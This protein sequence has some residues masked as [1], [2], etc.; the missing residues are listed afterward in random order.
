MWDVA[1]GTLVLTLEG[2]GNL[3]GINVI[4]FS[5]DGA[6]MVAAGRGGVMAWDAKTGGLLHA[7]GEGTGTPTEGS[8]FAI[9]PDGRRAVSGKQ[10][11]KLWDVATGKSLH[12]FVGLAHPT[13]ALAVS[14]DGK[15]LLIGDTARTMR[16]WNVATG[17][18]VQS[19]NLRGD[20]Y[21]TPDF[22][23]AA[24]NEAQ[25]RTTA[26]TRDG[27]RLQLWDAD[28]GQKISAIEG[29]ST[30]GTPVAISADGSRVAAGGNMQSLE[31][32]DRSFLQ[33][34]VT[35]WDA[36]NGQRVRDFKG[37]VG[38]L[39]SLAFSPDGSR[40]ASGG[41]N[42][43]VML[44][45]LVTGDLVRS[46]EAKSKPG[47]DS[48][49]RQVS[50]AVTAVAFSP[51]GKLLLSAGHEG[52][53]MYLWNAS[54]GRPVRSWEA[55]P[56]IAAL[57]FSA[58]GTLVASGG[59]DSHI[60]LWEVATGRLVHTFAG[61]AGRVTALAFSRDGHRV[62][63]SSYDGTVGVWNAANGGLLATMF[64]R[65]SGD[66]LTVTPEGFFDASSPAVAGGVLMVVSGFD[67]FSINPLLA[68]L[69]R[70]DLVREKLGG[71]PARKVSAAAA[72]FDLNTLLAR[73]RRTNHSPAPQAEAAPP[74]VLPVNVVQQ[75][76]HS[77]PLEA[78]AYSPN[79]RLV[80]SGSNDNMV[81]LW[82]VATGR[83]MRTFVG[84]SQPVKAVAFSPDGNYL[85]SGSDDATLKL[86]D[87]TTGKAVRSF[88]G[89]SYGVTA[90][91]FSHDG[92]YLLSGADAFEPTKGA[93]AV[94]QVK[95]WEVS[96]G[97]AV[98]TFSGH[99]GRVNTVAFSPDGRL[100]LSGG[101][102]R[103]VKLWDLAAGQE[104]RSFLHHDGPVEAVAFSPDGRLALSGGKDKTMRLWEV[105]TARELRSFAHP[106]GV[107]SVA[108]RPDG[109][110]AISGIS[111][112]SVLA[113]DGSG[114]SS[115]LEKI[116]L[117]DLT[118]GAEVRTFVEPG[119]PLPE[120]L[121]NVRL[122]D[123]ATRVVLSPD[124]RFAL[125]NLAREMLLWD[126]TTG[127]PVRTF[128]GRSSRVACVE[129]SPDGRLGVSVS[130]NTLH[131]WDV[132]SGKELRS[133]GS[134][135]WGNALAFSPDGRMLLAGTH[136]DFERNL[137]DGPA[138]S[139]GVAFS[140]DGRF[141]LSG[142]GWKLEL[143][144]ATEGQQV[145]SFA[146]SASSDVKENAVILWDVATGREVR[147]F[148]GHTGW[149][150]SVAFAPD[151]RLAASGGRDHK[152]KLW[153]VAAGKELRTMDVSGGNWF[154]EGIAVA[155]L[156]D[157]FVQAAVSGG[158]QVW[159]VKTGKLVGGT[160]DPNGS[161][162]SVRF[163]GDGQRAVS[164]TNETVNLWD[165]TKGEVLRS[166][167]GH[168]SSVDS[169][170]VSRDGG[171]VM[172]GSNDGTARLWDGKSG[173]ELARLMTGYGEWMTMTPEGFFSSSH[174]D[175]EMLS[176]VR[177]LETTT[178][179][180]IYQSLFNPDLVREALASDADGSVRRAAEVVNLQKVIDSGPAPGVAI[181]SPAAGSA[182][183]TD[184]VQVAARISDRGKGIGRIEWRVNGVTAGVSKAPAGPGP[185][186]EVNQ[187]LALDPGE[188][189]I[190]VIAYEKR[191]LLASLPARAMIK[192][193]APADAV[194]PQLHVLA[195][196]INAYV[197]KGGNGTGN[198][199]PLKLAVTDAKA[200]AAE[201]QRAGTGLYSTV[202]VTEVL[203]TEATAAGL[204]RIV[205]QLATRISPRDTFVLFAA[206]HG[207]SRDGRF[208]L[209]PQDYQGGTD[210]AALAEHAVDQTR[211]QDWVANRIKAR[212][213]I[214]LLDTCESGALVSGYTKSR[215]DVP[216]S[217]AAVG[218]LH[219]ATGR[220]VLT[221]AASGK[222]AFEGYNGHG[223][224]TYALMDALHHGDTNGN[225]V[226]EVSELV[227][228]V[229]DRLPRLSAQL[230]GR[231][232]SMIATSR[233]ENNAQSAQ[234]G[235]T[236]EDFALVRRLP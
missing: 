61:H 109:N 163:S 26:V 113:R 93:G 132:A 199:P 164:V 32:G 217:E 106:N 112:D 205:E 121:I 142:S 212:R 47:E 171:L 228:Y 7:F 34:R 151:G 62:F 183:A 192:F 131:L 153:D 21:T 190:E 91:A 57:A 71:D 193:S 177:G 160:S 117:W 216:A 194:K 65:E 222:P 214:I 99:S 45:D 234:F 77:S 6:Q 154:F 165:M 108:F 48:P 103:R 175:T 9:S 134:S 28:K 74:S 118:T 179:G 72:A 15:R 4:A 204:D 141:A 31:S 51:D 8:M 111:Y 206:A 52:T 128:V 231:G 218:R 196:G 82:D 233:S 225:G 200:F 207:T 223:L 107:T 39:L 188:N 157:R 41:K 232:I 148:A 70:P 180:Q 220:P 126:V 129:L 80:A 230:G 208:Y 36:A 149:V 17:R 69:H 25:G 182:S 226:I 198:F 178:V 138:G 124:G 203:D 67:T 42:G 210:P 27:A 116:R 209:I 18:P 20:A 110:F 187:A 11:L 101:D 33:Y 167:T 144:D 114:S 123:K 189:R 63:S 84:H 140:P 125:S 87:V 10:T 145:R 152:I 79:G 64:A 176:L 102:D 202:D 55:Q 191:N 37:H 186:Y 16:V 136:G 227:A 66:W 104:V 201:M 215:T 184:L 168:T 96:S 221:A 143:W 86:W 43:D 85:A 219:E 130:G 174:R 81:K 22:K 120:A 162:A 95:M 105:A 135:E 54:S 35:V 59:A 88:T 185:D 195:I 53:K 58:D 100:A 92:R 159:E 40:M 235:S 83:E 38:G 5:R 2:S 137:M 76:G 13:V 236:G 23:I 173:R 166:F 119:Q 155:F 150:T 75:I 211:L 60:H 49:L 73:E 127:K 172:S 46:L 229:Q 97:R 44:W 197:D 213:A 78:L 139:S 122:L 68:R 94:G 56:Q 170:A 115:S 156:T 24:V 161:L 98:R 19:G 133:F 146:G 89:H 147:R 14:P 29:F 158:L 169:V 50:N 224:F 1:S 90:V 30:D 3:R 12:D 181:V